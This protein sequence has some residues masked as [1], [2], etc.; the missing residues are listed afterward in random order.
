MKWALGMLVLAGCVGEA[1]PDLPPPPNPTPPSGERGSGSGGSGDP[2]NQSTVTATGYLTQIAMHHCQQAFD[3][4]ATY[5]N[6][7]ATFEATWTTSVSDCVA[8][9][10]D[11][12][13][14]NTI[15]EEIA[16]GR[17][18]YDGGAAVDCLAGIAF[19]ACDM[20]WTNGIQWAESCYSV[21]VGNVETGGSCESLY[22]CQSY[23]CDSA[24]RRCL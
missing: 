9:L 16:K 8:M 6:D 24:T 7:A 1:P 4:R 12:W 21:M 10:L 14:G 17:I 19:S 13:G 15:E 18:D 23:S 20:H 2:N 11:A 5:P 3:C 22:A